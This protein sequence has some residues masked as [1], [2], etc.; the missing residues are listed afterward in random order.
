MRRD[1]LLN[2]KGLLETKGQKTN[3]MI[4]FKYLKLD[5]CYLLCDLSTQ[6]ILK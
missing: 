6:T 3:L 5:V 2:M 4:M 1:F